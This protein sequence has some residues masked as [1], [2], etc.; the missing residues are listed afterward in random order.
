MKTVKLTDCQALLLLSLKETS[1][2]CVRKNVWISAYTVIFIQVIFVAFF[3]PR[4]SPHQMLIKRGLRAPLLTVMAVT[5][6]G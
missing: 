2:S 5:C 1:G 6:P 3:H 4:L